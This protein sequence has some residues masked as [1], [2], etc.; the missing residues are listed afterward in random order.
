MLCV[1]LSPLEHLRHLDTP[2]VAVRSEL[3][4]LAVVGVFKV[5]LDVMKLLEVSSSLFSGP[6]NPIRD[7]DF[8]EAPAV[9]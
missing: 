5:V 4:G 1:G 6:L 9:S 8:A 7:D 2:S 3:V